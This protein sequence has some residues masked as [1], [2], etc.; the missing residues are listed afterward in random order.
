MEQQTFFDDET[1][2]NIAVVSLQ[3]HLS[4][5]QGDEFLSAIKALGEEYERSGITAV[6][7]DF[8][9]VKYFGSSVLEGL[10]LLWKELGAGERQV[11]LCGLN[12]VCHQI[13]HLSHFDHVWSVYPDRQSAL[14]ALA[15]D[16]P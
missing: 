9:R 1:L 2:Q 6:L 7:V 4:N 3:S 11:S 16:Q 12:D 8:S 5:Y 14:S 10:R 13:I 15:P